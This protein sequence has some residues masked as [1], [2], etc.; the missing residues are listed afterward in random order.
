MQRSSLFDDVFE[1]LT[2]GLAGRTSRRGFLGTVAKALGI[3]LTLPV[4]A[5]RSHRPPPPSLCPDRTDGQS[6]GVH[7][8]AVLRNRR[9]SLQLLWWEHEYLSTGQHPL[10]NLVGRQLHQSQRWRHLSD[11]LP[12]LLRQGRVR[13]LYLHRHG[14][15]NAALPASIE[16][17][18]HLVLRSRIQH[19]LS[20]LKRGA[21]REGVR[22]WH[23]MPV[24]R[25]LPLSPLCSWS[26]RSGFILSPKVR[27]LVTHHCPRSYRLRTSLRITCASVW[28]ATARMASAPHP[29]CPD[30]P[31]S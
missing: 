28:D 15:R 31:V 23:G 21:A 20:L 29:Q 2:R 24:G 27:R 9:R 10:A 3:G 4:P 30:W 6:D 13:P 25:F 22:W 14:G 26:L 7:L 16:Q 11:L 17:R 5:S 18:H 8:L 1:G 12:G 19:G